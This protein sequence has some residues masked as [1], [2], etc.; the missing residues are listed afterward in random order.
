[1]N[2]SA[3]ILAQISGMIRHGR[4]HRPTLTRLA[5]EYREALV[6]EGKA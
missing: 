1:M 2:T 4:L 6:A 5:R 3:D